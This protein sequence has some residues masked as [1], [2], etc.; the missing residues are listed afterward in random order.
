MNG[1]GYSGT[2]SEC[3]GVGV[4]YSIRIQARLDHTHLEIDRPDRANKPAGPAN[5]F[6]SPAFGYPVAKA[7]R[8]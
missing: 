6:A 1:Y 4:E 7:N 8:C 2:R 3:E 5:T